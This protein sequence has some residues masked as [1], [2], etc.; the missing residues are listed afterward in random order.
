M[1]SA[2]PPTKEKLASVSPAARIAASNAASAFAASFLS[3]SE[4]FAT[5]CP[6][7]TTRL[8]RAW[9]RCSAWRA[10]AQKAAEV[11]GR[12]EG[13]CA[14]SSTLSSPGQTHRSVRPVQCQCLVDTTVLRAPPSKTGS[15]KAQRLSDTTASVACGVR[16]TCSGTRTTF[17]PSTAALCYPMVITA[18][19][20]GE[21]DLLHLASPSIREH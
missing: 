14:G 5:T 10:V 3:C 7:S 17:G 2:T 21:S 15:S 11:G 20:Q 19:F 6:P 13:S 16:Y 9:R 12:A 4:P 1:Q 18:A 8:A